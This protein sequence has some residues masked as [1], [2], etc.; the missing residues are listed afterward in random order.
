ME[1]GKDRRE[2]GKESRK[3]CALKGAELEETE[4]E[5]KTIDISEEN[6]WKRVKL[7]LRNL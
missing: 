3:I 5:L 1:R 7:Q 6:K 2:G 4:G